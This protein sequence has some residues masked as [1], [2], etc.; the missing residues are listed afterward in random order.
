MS[1]SLNKRKVELYR[2]DP[3][4]SFDPEG[5][6]FDGTVWKQRRIMIDDVSALSTSA[7][8]FVPPTPATEHQLIGD[9]GGGYLQ[10][11]LTEGPNVVITQFPTHLE[12]GSTGGI[13]ASDDVTLGGATPSHVLVPS[14]NAAATYVGTHHLFSTLADVSALSPLTNQFLGFDGTRWLNAYARLSALNDASVLA[15]TSGQNFVFD[16]THWTN[17]T[18]AAVTGLSAVNITS[19]SNNQLL[20][21]DGATSAWVNA[22]GYLSTLGDVTFP[23]APTSAQELQ[24][25]GTRWGAASRYLSTLSDASIVSATS[26][27]TLAYNG[28]R[29]ANRTDSLTTLADVSLTGPAANQVLSFDGT[30]WKNAT[31][32]LSLLGDTSVV[33][34]VASQ[35]LVF[36]GT[37][38]ANVSVVSDDSTLGGATPSASLAPTQRAVVSYLTGAD[39]LLPS[40]GAYAQVLSKASATNFDFQFGLYWTDLTVQLTAGQAS[41]TDSA[42]TYQPFIGNVQVQAFS[43]SITGGT[44]ESL[45]TNIQF[46]HGW[47]AGTIVDPHLHVATGS[48]TGSS[49]PRGAVNI[50]NPSRPTLSGLYYWAVAPAYINSSP[51]T[52]YGLDGGKSYALY[53]N[54]TTVSTCAFSSD[55]NRYIIVAGDWRTAGAHSPFSPYGMVG[56]V[57]TLASGVYY[58]TTGTFSSNPSGGTWTVGTY[59]PTGTPGTPYAQA[60]VAVTG[61]VAYAGTY[62]YVSDMVYLSSATSY[63]VIAPLP[64]G[65]CYAAY[66]CMEVN[67]TLVF[68]QA[69]SCYILAE[70]NFCTVTAFPATT[71]V[72]LTGNTGTLGRT[73]VVDPGPPIITYYYYYPTAPGTYAGVTAAAYVPALLSRWLFEWNWC[74]IGSPP[75]GHPSAEFAIANTI[76]AV[77]IEVS[78]NSYEHMLVPFG[79]IDGTGKNLS[80]VMIARV[81]RTPGEHADSFQLY[82]YA[83]SFDVH[84]QLSGLGFGPGQYDGA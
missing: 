35:L 30:R 26:G 16:G 65:L 50:S 3:E 63:A 43:G 44:T 82:L 53:Y 78:S 17:A 40:G 75:E 52:V 49:N 23:T 72:P 48:L 64:T 74:N 11:Y 84:M 61:S 69:T 32:Q 81:S 56:N 34:P 57:G 83:L 46:P 10:R 4:N 14:Q 8:H 21:Y 37:K 18:L 33:G 12:I 1:I 47:A 60:K 59:I 62:L 67:Y 24:F 68:S 28:A 9:F 80:S 19:P 27:Q 38:W 54:P 22:T 55:Q 70:G 6:L 77:T 41:A 20:E 76:R 36:N 7:N 42:P 71:T 13:A 79:S 5:I 29:W 45:H 73:V 58:P 31:P 15:P 39:G 2:L 66:Y 51:I 25:D